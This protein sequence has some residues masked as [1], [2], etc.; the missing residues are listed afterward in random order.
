[1]M[2]MEKRRELWEV[3]A[4]VIDALYEKDLD[5]VADAVCAFKP[6][7]IMKNDMEEK[8]SIEITKH[9]INWYFGPDDP[10]CPE[11][12]FP[13]R[14]GDVADEG[15]IKVLCSECGC[16]WTQSRDADNEKSTMKEPLS[17]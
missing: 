7:L 17:K 2:D 4:K 3:V 12:S 6:F 14:S 11:C 13:I 1:M 5:H 15:S 16:E 9:G 10:K 8:I